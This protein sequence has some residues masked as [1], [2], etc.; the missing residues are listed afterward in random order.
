MRLS[1]RLSDFFPPW[2][3]PASFRSRGPLS[4]QEPRRVECELPIPKAPE[5]L[6]AGDTVWFDNRALRCLMRNLKHV[7][8]SVR[9][10]HATIHELTG[11]SGAVVDQPTD[12]P[13]L[14]RSRDSTDL[15]LRRGVSANEEFVSTEPNMERDP[16]A[17]VASARWPS[18]SNRA[19][20][21]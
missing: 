11:L 8:P 15:N 20:I 6:V 14:F 3:P 21:G 12:F 16:K 18:R 2:N 13:L 10:G 9:G 19:A 4:T 1:S 17:L 5:A 7:F